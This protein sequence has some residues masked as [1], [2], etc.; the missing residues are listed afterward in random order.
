MADSKPSQ[1]A[2][3]AGE[4][5]VELSAND[6]KFTATIERMSKKIRSIGSTLQTSGLMLSA[7]GASMLAPLALAF[8]G[9]LKHASDMQTLSE[10]MNTTTET[11]SK[12][13]YAATQSG[14]GLDKLNEGNKKLTQVSVAALN[15]SE[16][17]TKALELMGV[18][19]TDFLN[20][21]LDERFL[22]I[23]D[24]LEDIQNP[25][26]KAKFLLD[27]LGES[28]T[29]LLPFLT[30]GRAG[31]QDLFKE[32][33]RNGSIIKT[34]DAKN[35]KAFSDALNK[36]FTEV[37]NTFYAVGFAFVDLVNDVQTGTSVLS[38]YLSMVRE[39]ARENKTIIQLL[40]AV[41]IALTAVGGALIAVGLITSGVASGVTALSTAF[42]FLK[43][44]I[45]QVVAL[46]FTPFALKLGLIIGLGALIVST[47][48][49]VG[50]FFRRVFGGFGTF[51][52]R[53]F[54]T[55]KQMIGGV[56]KAI[57]NG[58]ID[59]AW[60]VVTKSMQSIWF[61]FVAVILERWYNFINL[62]TDAFRDAVSAIRQA[63]VKMSAWVQ[64]RIAGMIE[65]TI[66]PVLEASDW[67]GLSDGKAAKMQERVNQARE[68]I[69][70]EKEESIQTIDK[71]TQDA[72]NIQ[73]SNQKTAVDAY[74]NKA[75]VL[76]KEMKA[77][78]DEINAQEEM[79]AA[80]LER[81]SP[82][83]DRMYRRAVAGLSIS[84]TL[85]DSVKGLFQS[86]D[87][88]GALAIGPASAMA[89]RQLDTLNQIQATLT[90]IDNKLEPDSYGP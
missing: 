70:K 24:A 31:L 22:K 17:Q 36:A 15:G 2:I 51:F 26:R 53:T 27:T 57:S 63:F 40:G 78:L 37:K 88:A 10:K 5:F 65:V 43:A 49:G 28:G 77:I 16:A 83:S 84:T 9:A 80:N 33:E 87:F 75:N 13:A 67:L 25:V 68:R 29:E 39:W 55:I 6:S 74:S 86:S 66:I 79:S 1:S 69:K 59:L 60:K 52:S 64:E 48:K 58:K 21:G 42:V 34:D 62:F 7:A 30:K 11:A 85:G 38:K 12:L 90:S 46:A 56:V 8:R 82:I 44:K 47:F 61:D 72:K 3:R 18:S 81:G 89:Q 19:A 32:A 45:L 41:T 76:R 23:A 35:A 73:L 54:D 50:D 71:E 20:L 4:A 14:I